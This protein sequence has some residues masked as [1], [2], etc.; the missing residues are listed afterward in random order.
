MRG[1]L[2]FLFT[3][4]SLFTSAQPYV[5]P[6]I[7]INKNRDL[8]DIMPLSLPV[9]QASEDGMNKFC[10]NCKNYDKSDATC[11][12]FYDIDF[13]NGKEY[14]K[15]R[16]MR[17]VNDKC[18]IDGRFYQKNPF[19]VFKN[20]STDIYD[21]YPWIVTVLYSICAIYIINHK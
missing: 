21:I 7:N 9:V 10:V 14:K 18:G 4:T 2:F 12:L 16:E 19:S 13:V 5:L 8:K 1:I 3:L 6:R 11:K 15:A 17:R 20:L